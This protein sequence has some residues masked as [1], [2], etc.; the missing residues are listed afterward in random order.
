[1]TAAAMGLALSTPA[2]AQNNLCLPR[3][4]LVSPLAESYSEELPGRGMRQESSIF[5]V[6]RNEDGGSW[7]IL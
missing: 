5:E 7:T 1:M 4:V 3:E 2:L 6:F